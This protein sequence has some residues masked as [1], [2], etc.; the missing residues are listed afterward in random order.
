MVSGTRSTNTETQYF[1][2]CSNF[3]M[4]HMTDFPEPF[5]LFSRSYVAYQRLFVI[6]ETMKRTNGHKSAHALSRI[7]RELSAKECLLCKL[8]SYFVSSIFELN[9]Y[10]TITVYAMSNTNS[11]IY[12]G[13]CS[14]HV[15]R[16]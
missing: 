5:S 12:Q 1:L 13:E 9:C 8:I 15:P 14:Y 2:N 4:K 16:N 6:S 7:F 10:H 11:L 3:L